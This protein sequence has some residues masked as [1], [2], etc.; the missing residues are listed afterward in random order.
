MMLIEKKSA[1][2]SGKIDNY[3]YLTGE[4]IFL[5]M[6]EKDIILNYPRR[7]VREL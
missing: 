3:K 5:I 7:T 2:S 6:E 1:L 4:E